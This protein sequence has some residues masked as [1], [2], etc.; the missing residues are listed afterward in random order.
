M[1]YFIGVVVTLFGFWVAM[2]GE[3]VPF[4]L[5]AG[6][7]SAVAVALMGRRMA[8]V[9]AE[10]APFSF[11][12]G[13]VT[14]WPWLIREIAKS[15]WDVTKIIVDPRLPISPTLVRVKSGQRTVV[16]RVT[17]AN[18]ITLTPGTISIELAGDEI[19]VHALTRTGAEDLQ[20]GGMN[21]RVSQFEGST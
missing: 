9:D 20:S 1:F 2:S 6:L 7:V 19:L 11:G 5:G 16:G 13:A 14:Y 4:L 15:A 12:P 8:V 17:Y 21:R 3:L 18:S 10:G